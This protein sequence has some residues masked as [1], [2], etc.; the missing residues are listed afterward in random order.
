MER[1]RKGKSVEW[2]GSKY[3]GLA[4]STVSGVSRL[5]TAFELMA[6]VGSGDGQS[7]DQGLKRLGRPLCS[8]GAVAYG[9]VVVAD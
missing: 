1:G 6:E 5:E 2:T 9:V 3:D 4:A 7:T 8:V